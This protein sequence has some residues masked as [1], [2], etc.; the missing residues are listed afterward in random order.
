MSFKRTKPAIKMAF[1]SLCLVCSE[2]HRSAREARNCCSDELETLH[3]FIC[4]ECDNE[5]DTRSEAVDCCPRWECLECGVEYDNE[6]E[7]ADCP[8][9]KELSKS[10]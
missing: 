8:E 9:C 2:E 6:P 1:F 7:A 5:H 4:P 3:R 10:D